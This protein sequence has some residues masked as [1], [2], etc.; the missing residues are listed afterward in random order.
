MTQ[1]RT[2]PKSLL[3]VVKVKYKT[4]LPALLLVVFSVLGSEIFRFGFWKNISLVGLIWY[5]TVLVLYRVNR[6]VYPEPN[7]HPVSPINGKVTQL[8]DKLGQSEIVIKKTWLDK[9][10]VRLSLPGDTVSIGRKTI[11]TANS[12]FEAGWTLQG[13]KL[14]PINIRTSN[15]SD[16][17]GLVIGNSVCRYRL[18]QQMRP[19]IAVG[20]RLVAGETIIG[21]KYDN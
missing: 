11:N 15:K 17:S 19:A 2:S 18:P 13:T 9:A 3:K 10:D 20:N 1:F 8:Q 4:A 5:V 16:L 21:C 12:T 7:N 14:I 6:E